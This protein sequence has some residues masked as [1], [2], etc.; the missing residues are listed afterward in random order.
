MFDYLAILNKL[1]WSNS[2]HWELSGEPI[3]SKHA[4]VKR[5]C[6]AKSL[7]SPLSGS[8]ERQTRR[9]NPS[10]QKQNKTL[11]I[12]IFIPSIPVG[13]TNLDLLSHLSA[14]F[15]NNHIISLAEFCLLYPLAFLDEEMA[16]KWVSVHFIFLAALIISSHL[17]Q[18]CGKRQDGFRFL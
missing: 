3:E 14:S 6:D 7:S 10:S 5:W 12:H 11:C 9:D 16:I 8:E 18:S 15:P 2:C 1:P 13:Q 17:Q 4:R